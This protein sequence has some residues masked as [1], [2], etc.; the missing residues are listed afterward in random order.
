MWRLPG[1]RRGAVRR[2]DHVP[3]GRA[4]LGLGEQ[5]MAWEMAGSYLGQLGLLPCSQETGL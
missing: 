4:S 2:V 3:P 1:E 5:V